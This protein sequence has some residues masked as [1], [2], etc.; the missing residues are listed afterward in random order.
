MK[1]FFSL[2]RLV[3]RVCFKFGRFQQSRHLAFF[4]GMSFSLCSIT[5][6]HAVETHSDDVHITQDLD[7][8]GDVTV[9]GA[10]LGDVTI[11]GTLQT[12][13]GVDLAGVMIGG[14]SSGVISWSST[15]QD[16]FTPLGRFSVYESVRISVSETGCGLGGSMDFYVTGGDMGTTTP[17]ASRVQVYSLG[18]SDKYPNVADHLTWWVEA[19]DDDEFYLAAKHT[20]GC[21][22]SYDKEITYTL[23]SGWMDTDDTSGSNFTQMD[24]REYVYSV[25]GKVGIGT[26]GTPASELEVEGTITADAFSGGTFTGDGSGL[27]NLAGGNIHSS[28]SNVGVGV[29]VPLESLDVDGGLRV[30]STSNTN[31]GTIQWNGTDFRGY[32]GSSWVSLTDMAYVNDGTESGSGNYS[33]GQFT[34]GAS[35]AGSWNVAIGYNA[36][37]LNT[38]GNNNVAIGAWALDANTE[39]YANVAIGGGLGANTTGFRNV[40]VGG[41]ALSSCTSASLNTAIGYSSGKH[42]TTGVQNVTIGTEAGTGLTTGIR[43]VYIGNYTAASDSNESDRLNI[44]GTIYGDMANDYIGIGTT[45]LVSPLTV[46][47]PSSGDWTASSGDISRY[48][49]TLEADNSFNAIAFGLADNKVGAAIGFKSDGGTNNKGDLIFYTKSTTGLTAP[50]ERMRILASG[51]VGIGTPSPVS[52]LDVNGAIT[53]VSFSGDG[54]ALTNLNLEESNIYSSGGYLGIGTA[55][56]TE[57]LEVAGGASRMQD[58]L[59]INGFNTEIPVLYLRTAD[60]SAAKG[61]IWGENIQMGKATSGQLDNSKS[62]YF[63]GASGE[64][65]IGTVSPSHPLHVV[66]NGTIGNAQS[67]DLSKGALR[68]YESSSVSLYADGNSIV[69]SAILALAAA[70]ALTLGSEGREVLRA[71]NDTLALKTG[72]QERLVIESDGSVRLTSAQGDIPMG[73]FQ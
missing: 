42:I 39:G 71:E 21:S 31:A 46:A 43:N 22:G 68:I 25:E 44:G 2:H 14:V 58:K 41:S 20:G 30:G 56:P 28:G 52:K 62:L 8:D 70:D 18:D 15:P 53:A 29:T 38:T 69:T 9:G 23:V 54:S 12:T 45:N 67:P 63:E 5:L 32:N 73:V 72:D 6:L 37:T 7:V 40:G 64:M 33:L 19:I 1:R 66:S 57:V 4:G 16:A 10:L 50:G 3:F 36:L 17:D 24:F 35:N 60:T 34:L 51:D 47:I 48:G 11:D 49:L 65:G 59:T 27:T 55:S 61:E 13:G 26:T